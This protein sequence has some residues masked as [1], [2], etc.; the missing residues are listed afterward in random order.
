MTHAFVFPG[1]GSQ[2]IGMLS[3]LSTKFPLV[4]QTFEEAS[5]VLGYDLW[6]LSQ[7]GPEDVL[8]QTEKTQPILLAASV[9]VWRVWRDQGGDDPELMAGHSFGE[10]SALVCAEAISF[11]DGVKLAQLRGQFMQSASPEGGGAVAAILGLSDEE[12]KEICR[13]AEQGYVVAPANFNAPGQVVIAGHKVAVERAIIQAEESKA[14]RVILLPITV[15]VHTSLM[16]PAAERMAKSL[17]KVTISMPKIPVIHNVD[18]SIKSNVDGIRDALVKQLYSPVQWT[19]TV[20]KMAEEGMIFVFECG[21]GK[22][23]SGLNK[24]IARN[25]KASAIMDIKS[26]EHALNTLENFA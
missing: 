16:K 22:V 6:Q 8:N 12:V 1:Q 15:P 2:A 20:K 7:S 24:R 21:H 18:A 9:A 5:K 14:K 4:K 23:L 19:N 11:E 26:L 13:Y 10:Y 17:D 3:D 25:L